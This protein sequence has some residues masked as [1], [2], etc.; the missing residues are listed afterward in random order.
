MK[1]K[2]TTKKKPAPVKKPAPRLALVMDTETTGLI[3][4]RSIAL[5]KLPEVIEFCGILADIT[6]GKPRKVLDVLVKPT[7]PISN[8][9]PDGSK[10]TISEITGITND[11]L[12]DAKPF[13]SMADDIIGM[14]E[15]APL[16]IA[17]NASFDV[18]MLD[19]EAER[20]GRKIA[21]PPVV[22]TIEQT[23]HLKGKRMNLG[24]MHEYLLG[25]KFPGAHRARPD[26][27][28]LLRVATKLCERGE[29]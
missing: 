17:Q 7:R 4:N 28:A 24:D 29:I 20:L 18:E 23:M 19:I 15:S 3:S 26:T 5:D 16:V 6:T 9:P 25:A 27:E 2:P 22:C 8:T 10:K 14:I 12:E 11:M 1:K 21:W 13:S